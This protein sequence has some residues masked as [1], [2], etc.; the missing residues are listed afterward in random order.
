MLCLKL[1]RDCWINFQLGETVV[2]IKRAERSGLWMI[3]IDAPKS[4]EVWQ[5]NAEPEREE[6]KETA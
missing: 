4:V 2:R 6:K 1:K 3:A 5:E